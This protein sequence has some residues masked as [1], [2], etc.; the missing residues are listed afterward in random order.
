MVY[1]VGGGEESCESFFA[2]LSR[3]SFLREE[4][5]IASERGRIFL[6]LSAWSYYYRIACFSR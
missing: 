2:F 5:E 4:E 1:L 6:L 3:S